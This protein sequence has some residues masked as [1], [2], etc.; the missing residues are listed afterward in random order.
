MK[1]KTTGNLS[2]LLPLRLR[3]QEELKYFQEGDE[4]YAESAHRECDYVLHPWQYEMLIRMN[5]RSTF[6]QLIEEIAPEL[7]HEFTP[8]DWLH[9]YNWLYE[10][11][12]VVC[13]PDPVFEVVKPAGDWK[14]NLARNTAI[15]LLVFG[16][17]RISYVIA[18]AFEPAMDRVYSEVEI[19]LQPGASDSSTESKRTLASGGSVKEF[20]V[21]G[22]AV[23][24]A[25]V[26]KLR[27]QLASCRVR[28]DEYYLQNDE[29]GYRREV[30]RMG[31]LAREIGEFGAESP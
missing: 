6:G 31:A 26:E 2:E 12:L 29:Q 3:V 15:A 17:L 21:S 13:A 11:R 4:I 18:P 22:S 5:G 8:G 20:S 23:E 19:W 28:R 30:K 24:N 10:E 1:P 25:A 7:P 14:Y 9:F 16:I 27:A